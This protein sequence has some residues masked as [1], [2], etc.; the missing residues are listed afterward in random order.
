MPDYRKLFDASEFLFAHDLDGREVVVTIEKVEAGVLTGS[1]G[2]QSKKPIA[3]FVGATKKLALNK[4]N[5]KTLVAM[6]GSKNT[7]DWAGVSIALYPT[8][9]TMGPDTVDCIRVRPKAVQ[10]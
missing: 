10:K 2:K 8:T 1:G 4:T 3:S 5:C 7:D 9:T 6:T